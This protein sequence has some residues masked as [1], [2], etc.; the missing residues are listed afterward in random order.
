M[1]WEAFLDSIEL[2]LIGLRLGCCIESK[3]LSNGN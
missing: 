2:A 3:Y 1:H